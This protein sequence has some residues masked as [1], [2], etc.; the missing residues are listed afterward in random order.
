MPEISHLLAHRQDPS[1]QSA[2][3]ETAA[4]SHVAT[5]KTR[6]TALAEMTLGLDAIANACHGDAGPDCPII[7]D[8]DG[9]STRRR[10]K[11]G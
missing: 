9:V 1:R 4:L 8:L 10:P 7:D 6:I 11:R 5:L 2:E 3:V